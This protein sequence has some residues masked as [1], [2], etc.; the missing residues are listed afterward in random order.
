MTLTRG[1]TIVNNTE[2]NNDIHISWAPTTRHYAKDLKP[3]DAYSTHLKYPHHS[4]SLLMQKHRE[5]LRNQSTVTQLVS[6]RTGLEPMELNSRIH[7]PYHCEHSNW[8]PTSS[9]HEAHF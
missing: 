4:P 1:L 5:Q 9:S 8:G 3:L 2:N 6:S 7:M